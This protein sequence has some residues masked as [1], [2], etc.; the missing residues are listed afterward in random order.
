[1][2]ISFQS[3]MEAGDVHPCKKFKSSCSICLVSCDVMK[4]AH[5]VETVLSCM[6][7][8]EVLSAP[9]FVCREWRNI[10]TKLINGRNASPVRLFLKSESSSEENDEPFLSSLKPFLENCYF[11]PRKVF[12]ITSKKL[13]PTP[14]YIRD[15][16]RRLCYMEVYKAHRHRMMTCFIR[17]ELVPRDC[18]VYAI[19]SYG[20]YGLQSSTNQSGSQNQ[21]IA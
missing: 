10:A 9:I 18:E 11:L 19:S 2:S 5:I 6:T 8:K 1:M 4:M 12:V 7:A 16:S 21:Q 20:V 13:L 3:G 17:R 14:E 15:N